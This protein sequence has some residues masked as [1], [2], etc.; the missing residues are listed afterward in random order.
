M[1][2]I[3]AILF[4]TIILQVTVIEATAAKRASIKTLEKFFPDEWLTTY[5]LIDKEGRDCLIEQIGKVIDNYVS[6]KSNPSQ[7]E[8]YNRI[9]ETCEEH[10]HQIDLF[11][12]SIMT[13]IK[14]ESDGA[15]QIFAN[16]FEDMNKKGKQG[17]TLANFNYQSAWL[18]SAEKSKKNP[19]EMSDKQTMEKAFPKL[20]FWFNGILFT[21]YVFTQ[22][23]KSRLWSAYCF[24]M[25]NCFL[26]MTSKT[27]R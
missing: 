19:N 3:F 22:M 16:L 23:P 4:L 25:Q 11:F 18:E 2:I 5:A 1:K 6:N 27:I 12:Q 17:F 14:N 7:N 9:E 8:L 10:W 24:F 15:R 20:G 13:N 26:K 21:L